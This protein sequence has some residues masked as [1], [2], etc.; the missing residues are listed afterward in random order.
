MSTSKGAPK[1]N[2]Y[3]FANPVTDKNLFSGRKKQREEIQYYLEQAAKAPMPIN[4]A[5]L[6]NRAAGKTSLLNMIS[7]QAKELGFC[8]VRIDLNEGDVENQLSFFYKLFDGIFSEVCDFEKKTTEGKTTGCFG[9][10]S[11]KTYDAYLD[12]TSAYDIPEDKMWSPFVFPIQYA[13]AMSKNAYDV[14]VSDA[15]IKKDLE[16]ISREACVP[17]AI[18]F[19]ECNVLSSKR[20]LLEMIRNIFMNMSGY[21]LVFTGT[22]DLFP[23][24]DEVFSPIVRQFKRIDVNPF[25]SASEILECIRKPFKN[26]KE[27]NISE[28]I[29]P[30]IYSQLHD[31]Q[32]L[33]GGRPYEIQLLCHFMFK[34][35][36]NKLDDV[37]KLSLGV[38]NDVLHELSSG[39]D[40][41]ARKVISSV[42]EID[43][44][45]LKA[46]R[47]LASCCGK[48]SFEDIWSIEYLLHGESR[49]TKNEL[50]NYYEYL[51]SKNILK[52]VDGTIYFNGD[53]FDK[54]YSKY[55]S[56][57][58]K[59]INLT[60][61]DYNQ[62]TFLN[63]ML[64]NK[65]DKLSIQPIQSHSLHLMRY[66]DKS[67]EVS[68]LLTDSEI[69]D[70]IKI[71]S[72]LNV[73]KY[74]NS[75]DPII[76]EKDP[77]LAPSVYSI[78]IDQTKKD[79]HNFN[80]ISIRLASRL[81]NENHLFYLDNV[82]IGDN[83]SIDELDAMIERGE[84]V[85][86]NIFYAIKQVHIDDIERLITNIKTNS[87]NTIKEMIVDIHLESLV[88]DYLNERKASCKYHA[89]IVLEMNTELELQNYNNI[90]YIFMSFGEYDKAFKLFDKAIHTNA[91]DQAMVLINYNMG[92]LELILE[93]PLKAVEYLTKCIDLIESDEQPSSS[94]CIL[95]PEEKDGKIYIKENVDTPNVLT[96]A[97]QTLKIIGSC[98]TCKILDVN[99][100]K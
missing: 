80:I 66:M 98:S 29:D 96:A 36:E 39:K 91:K 44:K 19:D 22:Y 8:V 99:V 57:H 95:I 100:S 56:K 78:L 69:E 31:I 4:L 20:I 46:L 13:K 74:F 2:P 59:N 50:T 63:L 41:Y 87:S 38:V 90:G 3:D 33:T 92:I 40:I 28:I 85:G 88:D 84:Q 70:E 24:M 17:I 73:M 16:F 79:A 77:V 97:H 72:I 55:F 34:R 83:K 86:I 37:M 12:M 27:Y 51:I 61:N 6:G 67:S 7:I 47:L 65:L 45:A 49:W 35:Y 30:E 32:T 68:K 52:V 94:A 58:A 26:N 54:I 82:T 23:V 71:E 21:M 10:K 75:G 11:G 64:Y 43:L 1:Y 53:D 15:N 25:A 42:Q 60:I 81:S 89:D 93:N 18:L 14:K 76:F 62:E 9:G 48:A 5:L